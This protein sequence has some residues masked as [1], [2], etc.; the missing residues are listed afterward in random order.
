[1]LQK[2]KYGFSSGIGWDVILKENRGFFEKN[3][4]VEIVLSDMNDIRNLGIR[5][6]RIKDYIKACGYL[7]YAFRNYIFKTGC[8][9]DCGEKGVLI[10]Y[11]NR[12]NDWGLVYPIAKE[13]N[14]NKIRF[15]FFVSREI[16]KCHSLELKKLSYATVLSTKRMGNRRDIKL[17]LKDLWGLARKRKTVRRM[18]RKYRL[19]S[20][21]EFLSR[22][23][24]Y[25]AYSN[26]LY[27]RYFRNCDFSYSLGN[28]IFGF[29]YHGY[30]IRH[31]AMQHG[32]HNQENLK[33][34]SALTKSNIYL[35]FT[36]GESHEKLI[37]STYKTNALAVGSLLTKR[38]PG[39]AKKGRI[40]YFTDTAWIVSNPNYDA[41]V[42]KSLDEFI[43]LYKRYK[44]EYSFSLKIHPN[45]DERYF[46]SYN[47]LFG[48]EIRIEE[49]GRSA[50]DVLEETFI[51]ISLGS[52]VNIQA[53]Q[54]GVVAV[55]LKMDWDIF[56]DQ[57]Y[58]YR[59]ND[60]TQIDW[61]LSNTKARKRLMDKQRSLI[62]EYDKN[63]KYPEKEV[64]RVI[65][66]ECKKGSKLSSYKDLS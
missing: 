52:T 2:R 46:R 10:S 12:E 43:L 53:I 34:W 31:F 54:L 42:K 4:Y 57:P 33:S 18:I 11:L 38:S 64:V 3:P 8:R 41:E 36:Y 28:R 59:V 55:Q 29:L 50:N 9:S 39:Y 63:V 56:M 17:H 27:S 58:S 51:C 61:I 44:S 62:E 40:V 22:Y 20:Y 47:K 37:H 66:N 32:E 16:Y 60:L 30:G 48:N 13:L 65:L 5:E 19:G 35:A 1:M 21:S 49:A 15:Y 7:M 6:T 45:D 23:L 26:G 24:S 25:C 14:E